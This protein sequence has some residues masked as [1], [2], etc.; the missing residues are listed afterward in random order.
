MKARVKYIT[1]TN[2]DRVIVV[3]DMHGHHDV[4]CEA[5]KKSGFCGKDALVVLGDICNKGD[6]SLLLLRRVVEL[7]RQE[8][9]HVLM[10]NNDL[11]LLHWLDGIYSDEDVCQWLRDG[12]GTIIHDMAKELEH[13]YETAEAVRLLKRTVNI[14]YSEEIR[15][16][17]DLPHIIESDI[18]TFV[19]AGLKPGPLE[20]QEIYDCLSYPAFA[21]QTYVFEKPLIVGHWPTAN[22]CGCRQ[23]ADQNVYFNRQTNVISIDGGMGT[24]YSCQFNYLVLHPRDGSMEWGYCDD[25]PKCRALEDQAESDHY[26][27]L[28]FPNS[29]V[30][31]EEDQGDSFICYIPAVDLRMPFS[32]KRVYEYKG[33][34]YCSDFTTYRLPVAAGE[35][36]SLCRILEDGIL[37]MRNGI[38]GMYL[39]RYETED[40]R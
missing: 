16:L 13:P 22:Y 29:K 40:E 27:N 4:F 24:K 20:K 32:K 2:Y 7:A 31:I 9:V 37:V 18:A 34:W 11:T 14:R 3:S 10:G 28:Q 1:L 35:I 5:L 15:F 8:N 25:L 39:G 33:G 17:R 6:Q 23:I 12:S 26:V 19:H 30:V 21:E 38:V 36:L